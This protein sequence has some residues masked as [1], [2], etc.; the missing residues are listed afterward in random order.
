MKTKSAAFGLNNSVAMPLKSRGGRKRH[1]ALPSYAKI[2]LQRRG[3]SGEVVYGAAAPSSLLV[4]FGPLHGQEGLVDARKDRDDQVGLPPNTAT[5]TREL[6]SGSSDGAPFS[7][8]GF[9]LAF[10][11]LKHPTGRG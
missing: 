5:P 3:H 9:R 6:E 4:G 10:Q 1:Q 8:P 2:L 11:L 7:R